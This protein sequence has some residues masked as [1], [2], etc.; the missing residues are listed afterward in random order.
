M[1]NW[2]F[3]IKHSLVRLL[4]CTFKFLQLQY[5]KSFSPILHPFISTK[6]VGIIYCILKHAALTRV[7]LLVL[8]F[9]RNAVLPFFVL[10]TLPLYNGCLSKGGAHSLWAVHTNTSQILYCSSKIQ[11]SKQHL[12]WYPGLLLI[13]TPEKCLIP[14]IS[15]TPTGSMVESL[16]LS[17]I[18]YP[19]LATFLSQWFYWPSWSEGLTFSLTKNRPQHLTLKFNANNSSTFLGDIIEKECN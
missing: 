2:Y 12:W 9:A 5:S 8:S 18:L 10:R 1:C 19:N 6:C 17:W 11:F 13:K 7:L 3:T 16:F 14:I 4:R 15:V